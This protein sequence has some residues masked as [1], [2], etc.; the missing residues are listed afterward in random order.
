M[1]RSGKVWRKSLSKATWSPGREGG[2]VGKEIYEIF[3]FVPFILS[4]IV[5][6]SI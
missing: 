5:A 4:E 2:S 3:V 1:L 6:C